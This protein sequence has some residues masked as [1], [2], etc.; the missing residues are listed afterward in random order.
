MIIISYLMIITSKSL[1][2][3]FKKYDF[4]LYWLQYN[5]KTVPSFDV[6]YRFGTH[7]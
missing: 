1:I 2:Y 4:S 7:V 6:S 5:S 3:Y